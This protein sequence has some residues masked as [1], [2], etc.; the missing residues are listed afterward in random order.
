MQAVLDAFGLSLADYKCERITTGHINFTYKLTG[1][2]S[3][4]LQRINKNVFKKPEAIANN[5]R[6]AANHLAINHP[7][8][9][10]S[11]N[12]PDKNGRE[13]VYDDEGFPWRLFPYI[14]NTITINKISSDDEAFRAAE[15]FGR[16]TAN[17]WNCEARL[18]EETIPKFHDLSLRFDQFNEAFENC[19]EARKETAKKS[20]AQ[21]L[22]YSYLV[23]EFNELI[24]SKKLS[25][26]VMHNDTKINNIL[27]DKS[28]KQVV[29]VIDLDTLMPGYFIYDLGDMIRTFVSPVDEE[30]KDLTKIVFRSNVYKAVINGYFNAMNG[31]LSNEEKTLAPL[32]GFMMTYI[33]ALRFLTDYLNG[34]IYYQTHYEGQNLVRAQNQFYLLSTLCAALK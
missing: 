19:P 22:N 30:E 7:E 25:L 26:H 20:I 18:F 29:S 14:D 17:L 15:G 34:D 4:I 33:M 1:S 9:F 16:L 5:I 23:D 10:F 11:S 2:K 24:Q 27:F 13:L 28:S 8:Y 32:A 3:F 21:A 31:C 6:F 12:I